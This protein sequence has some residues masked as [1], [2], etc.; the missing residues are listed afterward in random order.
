MKIIFL[1]DKHNK[2]I[3]P[4]P[5][6]KYSLETN[7]G[8]T[9]KSDNHLT[10]IPV[11]EVKHCSIRISKRFYTRFMNHIQLLKRLNSIKNQQHWIEEAILDKLKKKEERDNTECSSLEK[12][13]S[14]K[15]N[16]QIDAKVERKVEVMKKTRGSFTKKQWILE[17]INEKLNAEEIETIIKT[18]ELFQIML[19]EASEVSETSN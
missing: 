5:I 15:I 10:D 1:Y 4:K 19:N 7:N 3:W 18:K 9:L 11:N 12:Y 6:Q 2:I 14:F 8:L 13:L 17:A 16:S